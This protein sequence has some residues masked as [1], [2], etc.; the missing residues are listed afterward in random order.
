SATRATFQ[1][2]LD[3][4]GWTSCTSPQDYSGLG[5]GSHTFQVRSIDQAGNVGAAATQSWSVNSNL[6]ALSL[7]APS[8][9][10]ATN[11]TTPTITGTGGVASGDASTVTVKIYNGTS[12]SGAALETITTPVSSAT[13]SWSTHP[14]PALQEGVYTVYA[15]QDGSAGTAY[16]AAATFTVDTTPPTT[17]ITSG[18]QGT[19]AATSAR[20]AFTSSEA[21]S[22]LQ[23]QL[24]GGAWTACTSPQSYSSLAVG[25]HTFSVRATDS[26]GN[27][28]PSPP[29]LTWTIDT[30]ANVPVTLTTPA[31]GTTTS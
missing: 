21:A 20:F 15:Q 2:Q 30:P 24:D 11:D 25:T 17:S 22:S 7:A 10:A 31:D 14:N 9:G 28:D 3:G 13:G 12:I 26:A 27:V 18:P 6:P 29:V 1:C 16:T 4:G 5:N 8:D 19:T 23:C